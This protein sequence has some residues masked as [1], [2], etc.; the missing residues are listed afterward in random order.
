VFRELFDCPSHLHDRRLP[1]LKLLWD[2]VDMKE[3][4]IMV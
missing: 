1:A 2:N 4:E 3:D